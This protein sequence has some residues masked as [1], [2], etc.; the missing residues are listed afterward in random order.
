[1][2]ILNPE[3]LKFVVGGNNDD[4]NKSSGSRSEREGRG[5]RGPRTCNRCD[6]RTKNS[7]R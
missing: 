1:M 2:I 6:S 7:Y 5:E 4:S 3:S